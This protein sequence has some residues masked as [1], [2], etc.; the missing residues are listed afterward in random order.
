MKKIFLLFV[1]TVFVFSCKKDDDTQTQPQT[2]VFISESAIDGIIINSSPRQVNDYYSGGQG[3]EITIGWDVNGFAMRGFISFNASGIAP[4]SSNV[5]VIDEAV[6]R[7]YEANTN[8]QPFTGDGIRTVDCYLVDYKTLDANDYDDQY[9]DKC[10]VIASTGF[11]VLTEHS[12][13]V[14]TQLVSLIK[15]YPS[16]SQFQFRLEFS[17]DD[18]VVKSSMLTQAM[19][20]IFSG[21]ETGFADYRPTLTIK[22]HFEKK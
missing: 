6:L 1:L 12:L 22:Y 21:D 13:N 5:L 20:N 4:N 18:N 10:G 19:W 8:L 16:T 11:N 15:A 9:W 3:K 14:T 7:V 17:S 2:K